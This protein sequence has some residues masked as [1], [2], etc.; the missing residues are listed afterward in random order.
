MAETPG[1]ETGRARRFAISLI[2][3][4]L[5]LVPRLAPAQALD[6]I[7]TRIRRM[8][9]EIYDTAA[10]AVRVPY[11]LGVPIIARAKVRGY[12]DEL[13]LS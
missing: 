11:E 8:A 10:W 5:G 4:L 12:V 2:L 9:L 1:P 6:P 7:E 13:P 3:V